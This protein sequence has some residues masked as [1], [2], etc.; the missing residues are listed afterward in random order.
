[1][2]T[3]ICPNQNWT[4]SASPWLCMQTWVFG[5]FIHAVTG[6]TKMGRCCIAY[7]SMYRCVS[8]YTHILQDSIYQ[9]QPSWWNFVIFGWSICKVCNW[10]CEVCFFC[11]SAGRESI[12]SVHDVCLPDPRETLFYSWPHE[13]RRLT[14][15]PFTA[16][17][18]HWEGGAF[19]C[20]RSHAGA[21]AHA[22]SICGLSWFK[23]KS[24]LFW[25]DFAVLFVSVLYSLLS[26]CLKLSSCFENTCLSLQHVQVVIVHIFECI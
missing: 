23:G 4:L 15:P 6:G 20:C 9:R 3:I 1:M 16:W 18:L 13:W 7:G 14:L 8:V 10:Q 21:W 24:K 22:Q 19:L 25:W 11:V 2:A 5:I 12:H 26:F 17:C